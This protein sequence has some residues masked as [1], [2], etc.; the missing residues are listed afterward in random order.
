MSQGN[1]KEIQMTILK[2]NRRV[3]YLASILAVRAA[4]EAERELDAEYASKSPDAQA[5]YVDA[6]WQRESNNAADIEFEWA[7]RQGLPRL[8]M[9]M[10]V[11]S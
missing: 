3:R 8:Q 1:H 9:A 4:A 6:D 5:S 11:M 10:G 2:R 7:M